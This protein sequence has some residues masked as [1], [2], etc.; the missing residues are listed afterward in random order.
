[1]PAYCLRLRREGRFNAAL[2]GY[3]L[4]LDH[5]LGRPATTRDVA[6]AARYGGPGVKAYYYRFGSFTAARSLL[7]QRRTA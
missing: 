6:A 3:L 1:V 2:L 4:A 7:A 5:A